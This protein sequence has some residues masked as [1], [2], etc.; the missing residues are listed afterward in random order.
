MIKRER[1]LNINSRQNKTRKVS[2]LKAFRVLSI[3]TIVALGVVTATLITENS[4]MPPQL[5]NG[6]NASASNST[7]S[8][9]TGA[10]TT[11]TTTG[12]KTILVTNAAPKNN[13]SAYNRTGFNNLYVLTINGKTFPV[14]YS[15]V[16]GKLV[17]MLGDKDRTTT[18]LVLNPSGNGGNLTIELPRKMIDS[19]GASN[20]DTKY[21]VKIDGKGVDYKEG[22]NNVNARVLS[23]KFSKD[24]RFMEI[25]GT[26][27]AR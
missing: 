19:K 14:K 7:N 22:A 8:K 4:I 16:G 3:V 24:N 2:T 21:L 9:A 23:V 15:I 20:A 10:K 17:G 26:Q 13:T 1:N 5:V 11:I 25:I 6:Q 12:N 18:V 27:M